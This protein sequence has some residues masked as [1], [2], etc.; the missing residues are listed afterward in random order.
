MHGGQK[1]REGNQD[2]NPVHSLQSYVELLSY[3]A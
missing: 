1:G 2:E 3:L